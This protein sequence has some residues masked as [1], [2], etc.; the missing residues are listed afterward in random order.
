M[1]TS[2]CAGLAVVFGVIGLASTTV[3]IRTT[4]LERCPTALPSESA[5]STQLLH[6]MPLVRLV[7]PAAPDGAPR[8]GGCDRPRDGRPICYEGADCIPFIDSPR[9]VQSVRPNASV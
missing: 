6:R 5:N 7:S 9:E 2:L 1:H 3:K 8:M 4:C